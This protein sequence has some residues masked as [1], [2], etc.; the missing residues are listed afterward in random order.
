M[1][2]GELLGSGLLRPLLLLHQAFY[3]QISDRSLPDLLDD[4]P[5]ILFGYV[6]LQLHLPEG[7]FH[8]YPIPCRPHP[9]I[10]QLILN[11]STQ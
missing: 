2:A 11:I 10:S 1:H 3:P 5:A 8:L 4:V 6:F 7:P 9:A